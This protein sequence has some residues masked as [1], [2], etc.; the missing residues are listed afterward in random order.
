MKLLSSTTL[1]AVAATATASVPSVTLNAGT[2][3]GGQCASGDAVYYKGIPYAEPPVG[4]LRFEP[5]QPYSKPFR[6]FN[7]SA[8][9]KACIQFGSGFVAQGQKSEDW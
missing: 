6:N 9:A 4:D 7:A 5:P 3:K 2:L 8:P 1:L